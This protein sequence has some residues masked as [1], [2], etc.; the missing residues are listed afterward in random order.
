MVDS[1]FT[2]PRMT[3]R[4]RRRIATRTLAGSTGT[5]FASVRRP[6]SALTCP[7]RHANSESTIY[8]STASLAICV[9]VPCNS[10]SK[11]PSASAVNESCA[12]LPG[13]TSAYLS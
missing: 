7:R 12:G 8:G 4:D 1:E 3:G 9:P 10:I 11:M 13:A 5:C 2:H 6:A